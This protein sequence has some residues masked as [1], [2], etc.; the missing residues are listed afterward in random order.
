MLKR[1]RNSRKFIGK[2]SFA[3]LTLIYA[4][5]GFVR[6]FVALEGLFPKETPMGYKVVVSVLILLGVWSLC[7]IGVS[8][9][10]LCRRKK[11]V[12]DGRNGKGVYVLYGDLFDERIVPKSVKRRNIC[13][14]VNRCFDTMVD[15]NLISSAT[16]HGIALKRLYDAGIYTPKTLDDTIRLFISPTAGYEMLT[17]Q[18]KPQGNLKR[19]EVGTAVDIPVSDKLHYFMVGVSAFNAELKAETSRSEYCLAIQRAIEFCDSHAQGY[20]VIMP[21]IGGFLSRTGQSEQDLLR[22]IIKCFELNRDRI[23][24]DIYIVVREGAKNAVSIV[25][26]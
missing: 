26:L 8:F 19:H 13:F 11:K 16:L 9:W 25:D 3:V 24:Q 18:Q 6:M 10:V 12:V 7:V 21:I 22:Y 2:S 17:P 1:L 4:V 5:L 14:A 15:D 20:P 23:N